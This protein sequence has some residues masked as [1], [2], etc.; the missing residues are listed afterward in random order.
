MTSMELLELLGEARDKYILEAHQE[1]ESETRKQNH[2]SARKAIVYLIAA[3]ICIS[4]L[5]VT[6]AAAG[7]IPNIFAAVKPVSQLDQD[8]L[9]AAQQVTQPQT[10]EIV[11][12]PDTDYTK[13][14]L[15]Q[16]YYDGESIALGFDLSSVKH[17]PIVGLQPEEALMEDLTKTPRHES[18]L[19]DDTLEYQVELGLM[20]QEEYEE[21]M[22]S[23]SD[24]AKKNGLHKLN[25]LAMDEGLKDYLTPENYDLFWQILE[26]DG[27]CCVAVP[28]N[29]YVGD[30]ISINGDDGTKMIMQDG[31]SIR[32]DY[33][34]EEGDCILLSPIPEEARNL[35]SVTVD[36]KLKSGWSYLYM[37]LEGDTYWIYKPNPDYVATF[38]IENSNNP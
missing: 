36:L 29:P 8:I 23:R 30:H 15:F 14:T 22:D 16:R 2:F 17:Q 19:A 21:N 37:E 5:T 24:H 10:P 7:W 32:S 18:G 25:Q 13:I 9:E 12:V 31:C 34:T 35:P 3:A 11:A 6:A 20:T 4:L 26:R 27:A 1:K 38:T 28:Y 33:T